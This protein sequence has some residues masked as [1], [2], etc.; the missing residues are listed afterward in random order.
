MLYIDVYF[1]INWVM[2]LLVLLLTGILYR[3]KPLVK[4]YSMAAAVGMG[5]ASIY[6]KAPILDI[7]LGR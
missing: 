7:F 5:G 2:N 3:N 6:N 4:R 1:I